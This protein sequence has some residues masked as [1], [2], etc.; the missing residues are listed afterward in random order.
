M[1]QSL[2]L[3]DVGRCDAAKGTPQLHEGI[4]TASLRNGATDNFEPAHLE[5]F[6]DSALLLRSSAIDMGRRTFGLRLRRGKSRLSVCKDS[7]NNI[8]KLVENETI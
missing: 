7:Q 1:F 4:A 2:E 6:N 5:P 3:S 8:A